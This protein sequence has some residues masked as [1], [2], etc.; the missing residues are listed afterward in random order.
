MADSIYDMTA[1]YENEI[2][3][4]AE[5]IMLL[6]QAHKIPAYMSFAVANS[7]T[8]TVYKNAVLSPLMAGRRELKDNRIS[9]Y[10]KIAGPGYRAV[11]TMRSMVTSGGSVDEMADMP[12]DMNDFDVM[13]NMMHGGEAEKGRPVRTVNREELMPEN[14]AGLKGV[15]V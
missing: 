12:D 4:K 14:M 7:D 15:F 3:K 10:M 5:E 13:M 8:E 1:V 2:R 11:K 9:E 6:C